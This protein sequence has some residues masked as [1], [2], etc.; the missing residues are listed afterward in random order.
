MSV[1]IGH[2]SVDQALKSFVDRIERLEG[3]KKNL[4]EDIRGLYGEAKLRGTDVRALRAVI[5]YRREDAEKRAAREAAV[6]ELMHKL[7]MV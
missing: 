7:G 3:E 6:D 5:K 4:A 2:N 1:A